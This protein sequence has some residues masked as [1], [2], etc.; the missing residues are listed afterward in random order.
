MVNDDIAWHCDIVRNIHAI[1]RVGVGTWVRGRPGQ[2][3]INSRY[4]QNN[5]LVRGVYMCGCV[6]I[7]YFER[8]FKILACGVYAGAVEHYADMCTAVVRMVCPRNN[9][10][11]YGVY[12][13]AGRYYPVHYIVVAYSAASFWIAIDTPT[14][15]ACD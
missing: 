13:G 3:A 2:N 11:H 14:M 5:V 7:G 4:F 8:V 6:F 10:I 1:G 15:D 12:G 9:F